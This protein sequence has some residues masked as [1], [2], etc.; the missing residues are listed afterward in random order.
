MPRFV[1]FKSDAGA[2]RPVL[3]GHDRGVVTINLAEADDAQRIGILA[4]QT[5]RL[6]YARAA[7]AD[8]MGNCRSSLENGC[9]Q[10]N[11]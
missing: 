7:G 1:D 4:D 9:R 3:T 10:G 5:A 2:R 6:A 8:S 11:A